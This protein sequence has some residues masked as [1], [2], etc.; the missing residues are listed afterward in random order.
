MA[1]IGT[2]RTKMT[3]WVVG[4]IMVA[5]AAFI[6]GSDLIGS[7]PNALIGGQD[8]SVGSIAGNTIS[9]KEFMDAVQ[10]R[11]T[12]YLLSFGR[13]PGDREM[14][15][16]RQQAWDILLLRNAIQPQ[17]EKVG[18]RVTNDE[19]WDM[20][21]GK[22]VDENIKNSFRDSAGNFDSRRVVEYINNFNSPAPVEPQA[23]AMWEES[24]YRWNT[25][26]KELAAGRERMKYENLLV[27][28]TYVTD[29]E[30]E[31]DYHNQNDVAEVAYLYVPFY[32]VS[33]S[34]ITVSDNDLKAYYTRNKKR[35]K[36]EE[37]RSL[38]YVLYPITPSPADSAAVRE[39]LTRLAAELKTTAD[40]SV[41][42][43]NN[44]DNP[45][46]AF[47]KYNKG[48]LPASISP[49]E[50]QP[51]FVKGPFLDGDTYKVMKVVKVGKDTIYSARASHILI[52]WDSET[53]EAKK[54]ARDKARKILNE[55][56]AGASF[57]EKA[58]EHGT[59]GTASKGGDLGW[60]QSGMMVKPFEKAVFDARKTG[61]LGDVVETQFGYHLIDV[62]AV[63]DNTTYSIASI[64][65]TITESDE[66][67]N[68][69]FR[70]ADAFATDLS[71][72]DEFKEKAKQEGLNV[73]EAND[74]LPTERRMNNL[75]DARVTISWAFREGKAGKV[76][77]VNEI[78]GNYVIAVVTNELEEGAKPF[79]K[80]KEEI[81]PI[82]KNEKI[83]E[84]LVKQLSGKTGTLEEIARSFGADAKVGTSS[85]LKINASSMPTIGFDP[86]AIGGAFSVAAGKRTAPIIG[87]TGVSIFE[88]K[89]LTPAPAIGDYTM[90]KN[91]LKQGLDGRVGYYITE[92]VR[93]G[94]NIKDKRYR[95]Y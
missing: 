40:D 81:R 67:R 49:E 1:L 50:L 29:A 12:N 55:I 22:N 15:T 91:Q 87:E 25:F 54:T 52:R 4:F 48:N 94:A 27:K 30:A 58:R 37:S 19:V 3:K 78:E 68:E 74:L 56:K 93:E 89:N 13:Q 59:D 85:D 47:S 42:A 82:V 77:P 62:T 43:I 60:F 23:R 65:R 2:L 92:A 66:T 51:G 24:R 5:L 79:E 84:Y 21:Q 16:L 36:T 31:R 10:E 57:A 44:S 75:N 45:S 7:G 83:G 73:Y 90:F 88:M 95:M 38:S 9:N 6:V 64:E 80:V 76:S 35:Y 61:L 72:V 14:P 86:I 63:K 33:D 8:T 18:V 46:N 53:D 17:Y 20:I 32:A 11:E 28:T 26:Q 71:G 39:E 69:A 34:Q 41:F 70:K